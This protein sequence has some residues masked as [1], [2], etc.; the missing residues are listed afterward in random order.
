MAINL[1]L[2]MEVR[3]A[4][5]FYGR[6]KVDY[7]KPLFFGQEIKRVSVEVE[8]MLDLVMHPLASH[9]AMGE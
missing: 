2:V 1:E 7:T 5:G 3:R 8:E 6:L 4:Q 9:D